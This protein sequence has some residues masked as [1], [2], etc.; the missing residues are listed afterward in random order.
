[1]SRNIQETK[2]ILAVSRAAQAALGT[3]A[4]VDARFQIDSGGLLKTEHDR[5][6][7]A[8]DITGFEGASEIIPFGYMAGGEF[9]QKRAKPDFILW[10]LAFALGNCSS[11]AAGTTG[12]QHTITPQTGSDMDSFT[13]VQ[14]LG[15][16]LLRERYL[17]NVI[18]EFTLGLDK[19]ITARAAV[20][21]TG[22][23]DVDWVKE[24]VSAAENATSLTVAQNIQG[25]DEAARLN[26][27]HHIRVKLDGED[28]YTEV[29]FSASPSATSITITAPGGTATDIT[30]EVFYVP[31]V[32]AYF[33]SLPS[34]KT[35]PY[36]K[37]MN[38]TL[39]VGA[40]W[41]GTTLSGGRTI[42]DDFISG[43]LKVTNEGDMKFGPGSNIE[44]ANS[45]DRQ[46]RLVV[47]SLSHKMRD[48]LREYQLEQNEYFSGSIK[49]TGAEYESG[50]NYEIEI[51]MPKLGIVSQNIEVNNKLFAV[52]GDLK[53]LEGTYDPIIVRGKNQVAT[54]LS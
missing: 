44:Y 39:K 28:H 6:D 40:H 38:L 32:A 12:Y 13:A 18:T 25:T 11:V 5:E 30:Y 2:S 35:E 51:I 20:K 22:Q 17:G 29:Q 9:S 49:I 1:M 27:I 37:V 3:A 45:F 16:T 8:D 19:W 31:E 24:D 10:A 46:G 43:E 48:I 50:H 53:A 21:G 26:S 47:W 7:N 23:K 41:N 4:T 36:L 54:Y 34:F 52:A 42:V 14:I 15:A 33:S